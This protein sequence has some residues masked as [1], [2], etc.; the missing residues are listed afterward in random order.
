MHDW[1]MGVSKKLEE[2]VEFLCKSNGIEMIKGQATFLS[3]NTLQLTNGTR[4]SSRRR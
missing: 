2:G 3:S 1:R 4:S